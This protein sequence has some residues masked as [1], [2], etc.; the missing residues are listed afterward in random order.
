MG[1]L[2]SPGDLFPTAAG[3]IGI[4][5]LAR[6]LE[7]PEQHAKVSRREHDR[8]SAELRLSDLC[9]PGFVLA[10]GACRRAGFGCRGAAAPGATAGR[11]TVVEDISDNI[12][13]RLRQAQKASQPV[14]LAC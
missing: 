13:Q 5:Q 8:T 14:L 4:E 6:C 9:N 2:Q 12:L 11:W 3:F 7:T 1:L 10:T